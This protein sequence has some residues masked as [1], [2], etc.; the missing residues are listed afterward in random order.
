MKEKRIIISIE[1]GQVITSIENL[2]SRAEAIGLLVL[3]IVNQVGLSYTPK[4]VPQ[5]V[6]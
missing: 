1:D 6:K 2:E 5:D 3:A 4:D